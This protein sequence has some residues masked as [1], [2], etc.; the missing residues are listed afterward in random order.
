MSENGKSL[1]F[2]SRGTGFGKGEGAGCIVLKRLDEAI[3][4]GDLVRA[5]IAGSGV[6]QD[7]RTNG[8]TM[9]SGEA[10]EEL[11]RHVYSH[12]NL[13]P[14]E[15]GFIEAHGTGTRVGA[16]PLSAQNPL[17]PPTLIKS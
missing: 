15:T 10:Q 11:M 7:G 3:R 6:N 1:A 17:V 5:V 16:A 12:Y 8:I 4:D 2:D 14:R 9:P 13:D